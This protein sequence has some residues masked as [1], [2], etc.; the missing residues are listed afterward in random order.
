[1]E[2]HHIDIQLER[3]PLKDPLA[4]L[5]NFGRHFEEA[6]ELL[7]LHEAGRVIG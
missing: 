2:E 6:R 7:G 4:A 1:V 5:G 3:H